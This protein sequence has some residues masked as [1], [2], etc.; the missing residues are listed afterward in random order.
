[1]YQPLAPLTR[2][3]FRLVFSFYHAM[4]SSGSVD[5]KIKKICIDTD[6]SNIDNNF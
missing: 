5:F 2:E 3:S 6:S 1:M 4:Q